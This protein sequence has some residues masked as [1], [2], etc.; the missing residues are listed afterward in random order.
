MEQLNI[1]LL[2]PESDDEIL[3]YG[4]D[5]IIYSGIPKDLVLIKSIVQN[6]CYR[7]FYD[8]ENI[9]AFCNKAKQLCSDVYLHNLKEQLLNLLRKNAINVSKQ[10]LFKTDCFYYQWN[11]LDASVCLRKDRLVKS[12]FE[13]GEKT[14]ILSFLYQDSWH[15]GIL[16]IIKDAAHYQELPILSNIPYF[17]PIGTFVEWYNA[18]LSNR[19][20]Q[21]SDIF[22]FERTNKV[23]D[24]S[25]QRIYKEKETDRYW[26]YD[27]FHGENKEHYE[28]F[29]AMGNH[30][31]EADCNG[32]VDTSKKDNNKSISSIL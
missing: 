11:E 10:Q 7:F 1:F 32:I 27:F 28:V 20:F 4:D 12:A 15:R 6:G 22:R 24:R 13:C 29:D 23:W 8:S 21:L 30:I 26:Y 25:K 3:A 18:R 31:G 2:F 9:V 14:I 17:N 19:P 16:P 5:Y